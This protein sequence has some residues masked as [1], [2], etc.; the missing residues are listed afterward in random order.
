MPCGDMFHTAD[1]VAV[2]LVDASN[3]FNSN[4]RKAELHN[5]SILCPALST[6]LHNTYSAA[7]RLFVVGK[8]KISSTE[9]TI[10]RDPLVMVMYVLA[11]V[12]LIRQL[13]SAI[14]EACQAWLA[15][16]ATVM[17]SLSSTGG[18]ICLL[19]DQILANFLMPLKL[20]L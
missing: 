6:V 17:G 11:V 14:L 1:C 13:R 5:I 19:M 16:D 2:L 7:F 10:Q 12:S 18:N 9:V 3:A 15:D 8:G 4:N 20:F